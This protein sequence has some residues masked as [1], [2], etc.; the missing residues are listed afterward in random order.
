MA[1]TSRQYSSWIRTI[2]FRRARVIVFS[3][4]LRVYR[5]L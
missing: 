5:R 4:K 1:A 3:P 2:I